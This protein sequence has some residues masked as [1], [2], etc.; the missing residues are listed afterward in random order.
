MPEGHLHKKEIRELD[1]KVM[2]QKGK[3]Q[4][5]KKEF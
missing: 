1:N 3:W 2:P 4:K 5:K